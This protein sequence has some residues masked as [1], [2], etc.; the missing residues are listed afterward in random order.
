MDG[1]IGICHVVQDT[2]RKPFTHF[3]DVLPPHGIQP[4]NTRTPR[5]VIKSAC[6]KYQLNTLCL[7][8]FFFLP[9]V[10]RR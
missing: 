4:L 3:P 10:T 6:S 1:N 2:Q 5:Q 9:T 7:D 8:L